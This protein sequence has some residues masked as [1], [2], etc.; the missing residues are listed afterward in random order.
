MN[1]ILKPVSIDQKETLNNLMEK[2]T[3]EFSQYDLIPFGKDGLF[4]DSHVDSYFTD[5]ERFPFFIYCGK[6]IAG[7]ALV[8]KRAE[9]PAPLDWAV[10]EFFIAYPF[11]RKGLGA[12]AMKQ[13]FE[14]FPGVWQ[15]KY[16]PKNKGSEIFWQKIASEASGNRYEIVRGNEDYYD[17]TP[18]KVLV[19]KA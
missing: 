10:A 1:A 14:R 15:I 5:P 13:L 16:H 4:H 18:S 7:L 6:D 12:S 11:R 17:G 9:C 19:F 2:H 8:F 3:Y